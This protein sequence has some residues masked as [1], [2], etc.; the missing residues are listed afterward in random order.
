M[1]DIVKLTPELKKELSNF[2]WRVNGEIKYVRDIDNFNAA[3][4]WADA[5]EGQGDCDNYMVS[6]LI[7]ALNG[8][9]AAM[10]SMGN[11]PRSCMRMTT[12]YTET[13]GYHA[14]LTLITDDGDYIL[15]N[16]YSTMRRASDLAA[17]GYL[18]ERREKDQTKHENMG[19]WERITYEG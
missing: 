5:K 1:A 14:V 6:K 3:D 8:V 15:D 19:E 9:F 7:D 11:L 16:R 18:F 13:G 2:N 4:F 17:F 12:C 10:A